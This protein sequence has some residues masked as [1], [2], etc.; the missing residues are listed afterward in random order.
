[1]SSIVRE[2]DVRFLATLEIVRR[3]LAHLARTETRL[4]VESINRHWVEAL[5][6]D[7]DAADVLEA[8]RHQ[9][10]KRAAILCS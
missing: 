8:F 10:I 4:G 5:E 7:L 6:T 2:A 1:M 9:L 3:E